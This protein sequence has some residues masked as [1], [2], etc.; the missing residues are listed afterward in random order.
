MIENNEANRKK[1]AQVMAKG[2]TS[3]MFNTT[4]PTERLYADRYE[5]LTKIHTDPPD[6]GGWF[7]VSVFYNSEQGNARILWAREKREDN[8][9]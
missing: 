1:F 6:D 9:D 5:F 3:S 8:E 2:I 7:Y 4:D